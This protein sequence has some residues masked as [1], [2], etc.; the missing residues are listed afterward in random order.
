MQSIS[1]TD[2]GRGELAGRDK[3]KGTAEKQGQEGGQTDRRTDI[4]KH[5]YMGKTKEIRSK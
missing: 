5:N 1:Q 3:N 2:R 4:Q